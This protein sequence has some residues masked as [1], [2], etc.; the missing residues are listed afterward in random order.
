ATR[1]DQR[2]TAWTCGITPW[3]RNGPRTIREAVAD[4]NRSKAGP[5]QAASRPTA[6]T[7]TSN[8]AGTRGSGAVQQVRMEQ[9][10]EALRHELALTHDDLVH[11]T[12]SARDA[13]RQ[14]LR[15]SVELAGLSRSRGD[16][17]REAGGRRGSR[18]RGRRG[19]QRGRCVGIWCRGQ[20]G[21]L[22]PAA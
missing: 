7:A 1:R 14:P 10:E 8:V 18:R 19:R 6:S 2:K 16:R 20:T 11:V 5:K 9:L 3:R 15:R 17:R 22:Y 13:G 21:A 12:L 4:P